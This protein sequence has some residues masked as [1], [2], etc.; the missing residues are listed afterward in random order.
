MNIDE[1][2]KKIE[3]TKKTE[4]KGGLE[5]KISDPKTVERIVAQMKKK[6]HEQGIEYEE[7]KG[8]I[9]ELRGIVSG[10]EAAKVNTQPVEELVEVSSRLVSTIGK[11]F[12]AFRLVLQ[13][14]A[15]ATKV[16][17]VS[18]ELAFYLYS[19]NIN[20][21]ARQYLAMAVTTAC[22][23]FLIITAAGAA[24][25]SFLKFSIL[26][27]FGLGIGTFFLALILVLMIPKR[28]AEQRGNEI[29]K[30]LPFALRHMATEL[31]AGIGLY[32][33]LETIASS[34]YGILSEEFARTI[35][36]IEEGTDTQEA[37]RH[38][39]LRSQSKALRNALLHIIRA[40][41][42]GGALST[43]MN[44]IAEDVSFNLQL[45][46]RDFAEKMNFFG[47]IF[48]FG[49]IVVPVFIAIIG[50]ILN[51]PIGIPVTTISFP[52]QLVLILLAIIYPFLLGG[53]VFYLKSIQP[54]V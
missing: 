38:F 23:A 44:E 22:L 2:R 50:T 46:I 41:K 43:V 51:A 29:S 16:F 32:K 40:L 27:A 35:N 52:P 48:I 17:P 25:S 18:K 53:L 36:E 45:S 33:T 15:G 1:L 21:S 5:E 14:I 10:I 54:S 26:L 6:Y 20:Y 47:V 31:R 42:T 30:D 34:D 19:A 12:L 9:A 49:G 37:L 24:A 28:V 8:N 39:A 4:K 3:E 7:T 11:I 13:P